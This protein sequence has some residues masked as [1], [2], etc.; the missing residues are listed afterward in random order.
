MS[1]VNG[2][3]QGALSACCKAD[4]KLLYRY[5]AVFVLGW[6]AFV[7]WSSSQTE[8]SAGRTI[9][10]SSISSKTEVSVL[11]RENV[12]FTSGKNVKWVVGEG[13]AWG[14]VVLGALCRVVH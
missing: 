7:A 1:R 5:G 12:Y 14:G 8:E 3:M 6:V 2:Y 13:G 11:T 9:T 10:N 4:S